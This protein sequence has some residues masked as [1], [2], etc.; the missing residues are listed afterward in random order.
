MNTNGIDQSMIT[1]LYQSAGQ[2]KQGQ[3]IP[4]QLAAQRQAQPEESRE[5]ASQQSKETARRGE[6]TESQSIDV[7]A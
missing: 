5:S 1:Q 2:K 4:Q 7:Y 3:P 6:A